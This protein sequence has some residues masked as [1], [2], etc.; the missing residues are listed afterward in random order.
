MTECGYDDCFT[1]PYPDCILT[2][3]DYVKA[4]PVSQK[5]KNEVNLQKET[6]PRAAYYLK[7]KDECLKR[8]RESYQKNRVEMLDYA[9]QYQL[10][11]K[12]KISAY[13]KRYYQANKKRLMKQ[14]RKYYQA[15][16]E[17]FSEYQR[18]YR[19]AQKEKRLKEADKNGCRK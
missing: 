17:K 6:N 16:R 10:D 3:D 9:R 12:E 2:E 19:R 7:N 4:D 13:K 5:L 18:Q 15:S 1:C 14:H 8:N 11:N